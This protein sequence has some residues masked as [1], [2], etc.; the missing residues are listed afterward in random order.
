MSAAM[1]PAHL[2]YI[3]TAHSGQSSHVCL[4]PTTE[5]L[6]FSQQLQDLTS[7]QIS[8]LVSM[9]NDQDN[10]VSAW[11]SRPFDGLIA[12]SGS[13]ILHIRSLVLLEPQAFLLSSSILFSC[14]AQYSWRPQWTHSQIVS[15][16]N[17]R[18]GQFLRTVARNRSSANA[19]HVLQPIIIFALWSTWCVSND[20]RFRKAS[21][22]TE[23]EG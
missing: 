20:M 21:I 2:R 15:D 22:E 10:R 23:A 16:V 7:P 18:N 11:R 12:R 14:F 17:G 1:R 9:A 19:A 5:M 4:M 8:Q 3:V 6:S 13:T